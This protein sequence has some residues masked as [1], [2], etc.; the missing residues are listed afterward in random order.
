MSDAKKDNECPDCEGEGTVDCPTCDGD[1]TVECGTCNGEG[2]L[3]KTEAKD[4]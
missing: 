1:G 4:E 2:H 3:D